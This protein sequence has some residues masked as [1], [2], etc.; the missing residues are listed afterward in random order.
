[1]TLQER[2]LGILTGRIPNRLTYKEIKEGVSYLGGN[3]D[4]SELE[5]LV[6]YISEY[7]LWPNQKHYWVQVFLFLPLKEMPTL[8]NHS[9]KDVKESALYRLRIGK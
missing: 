9:D 1:M 6:L 7:T 3:L 5:A 4:K 2:L 8:I